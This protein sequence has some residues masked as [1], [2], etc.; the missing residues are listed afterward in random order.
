MKLEKLYK[1]V[2]SIGIDNDLRNKKEINKLLKQEKEKFDKLSKDEREFY[3]SDKLFNPFSDTRILHG[4]QS[5]E[6]KKVIVG[7]DMEIGEILL[8][9]QLNKEKNENIDLIISHHPEGYALAQLYDVMKLQAD[10]L[11]QYG[12]T[13]SVAEQLMEKRI[14]EVERGILPVN[15][16]R[17][18]DAARILDLPMM[19]VHTP[20]DNCVTKYLKNLFEKEKPYNLKELT[21]LL[22]TIPEYKKSSKLQAPPKIIH[23]SE[24]N[25]CGKIYVDMTGGTG[26]S[27]DIFD[28]IANSGISTLV[29]MHIGEKHL[30][31]AKQANL[32]IVIAGH[33]S[34]DTLGL[35][36][37]FDEI[38]KKNQLDFIGISGFERFRRI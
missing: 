1:K 20:A 23:G 38:E 25:K 10:L 27:E 21:G 32:N 14:S 36:L 3:D 29:G 16:N 6:I 15:H 7:I 2:I 22:K 26:G 24:N 8:T 35:N 12:I 33:I 28:K 30:K 5:T 9:H 11:S 34:S 18:V 4:D 13:V 19:C 31:K 37:L 17:A